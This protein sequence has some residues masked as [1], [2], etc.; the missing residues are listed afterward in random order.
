MKSVLQNIRGFI[1]RLL[2]VAQGV[3]GSRMQPSEQWL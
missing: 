2:K 3:L 1:E